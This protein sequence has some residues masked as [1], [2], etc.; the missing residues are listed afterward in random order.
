MKLG[1]ESNKIILNVSGMDVVVLLVTK[2][3]FAFVLR[4]INYSIGAPL[5]NFSMQINLIKSS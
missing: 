5:S 4:E 2:Y 1:A 3:A